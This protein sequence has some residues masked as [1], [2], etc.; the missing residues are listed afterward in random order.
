[1]VVAQFVILSQHICGGAKENDKN[2]NQFN[3]SPGRDLNP[4]YPRIW[5][6]NATHPTVTFSREVYV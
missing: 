5:T 3:R 6:S 4:E 1:M 2:R